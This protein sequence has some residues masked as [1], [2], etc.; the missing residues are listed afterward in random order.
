M[1]PSL[2]AQSVS[3]ITHTTSIVSHVPL[4]TSSIVSYIT[5]TTSI[6]SYVPLSTSS[7]QSV[8]G[9]LSLPT[10]SVV[11]YRRYRTVG[12]YQVP[13]NQLK[14]IR[15]KCK[16]FLVIFNFASRGEGGTVAS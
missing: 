6:V 1:S 10:L 14:D 2:P 12:T 3:Y 5:L 11:T 4:S 8:L 15:N 9:N 7:N 13:I 16:T